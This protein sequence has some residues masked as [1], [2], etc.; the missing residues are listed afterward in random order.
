MSRFGTGLNKFGS[1]HG[2]RVMAVGLGW[3]AMESVLVN[4]IPLWIGARSMHFSWDYIQMGL[5]SN[6]NIVLHLA[7][8]AFIWLRTRSNVERA[9]IPFIF[10]GIVAHVVGVPLLCKAFVPAG[11]ASLHSWASIAVRLAAALVLGFFAKL[12][13]ARYKQQVEAK[14]ELNKKAR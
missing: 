7:F 3:S 9:A 5:V 4:L 14:E 10:A 13:L 8:I 1:E 6:I 2:L 12:F 11:S